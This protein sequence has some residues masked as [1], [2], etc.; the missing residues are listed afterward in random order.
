MLACFKSV[1][2]YLFPEPK[3]QDKIKKQLQESKEKVLQHQD[4][5][6]Y[7]EMMRDYHRKRIDLL[8][9]ELNDGSAG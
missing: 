2:D 3:R 5:I 4:Q 9:K 1:V 7:S 6:L 8:T